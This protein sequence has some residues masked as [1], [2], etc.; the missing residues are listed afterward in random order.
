MST[1]KKPP[2]DTEQEAPKPRV[3]PGRSSKTA[4]AGARELIEK[5]GLQRLLV[6][7]R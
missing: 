3:V 4:I 5:H 1:R 2:A 7:K 6:P